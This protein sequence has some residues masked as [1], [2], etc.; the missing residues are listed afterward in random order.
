MASA[1]RQ[2]ARCSA[3]TEEAS[4]PR[5]VEVTVSRSIASSVPVPMNPNP[6]RYLA[7]TACRGVTGSVWPYMSQW[8]YS[9]KLNVLTAYIP[10][11]KMMAYSRAGISPATAQTV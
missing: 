10:I 8:L 9:S 2:P 3:V 11:R 1:D 7:A 4:W 6:S 5:K